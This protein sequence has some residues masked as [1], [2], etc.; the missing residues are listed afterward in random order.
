MDNPI[1]QVGGE[2]CVLSKLTKTI[3]YR[4]VIEKYKS[5]YKDTV[6]EF[7]SFITNSSEYKTILDLK[8]SEHFL[9]IVTIKENVSDSTLIDCVS[10]VKWVESKFNLD[11]C[12]IIM[13]YE[14]FDSNGLPNNGGTEIVNFK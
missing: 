5:I 12:E 6:I 13:D 10:T 4:S 3:N 2:E 7:E 11:E 9:W 1:E 14:N 8:K